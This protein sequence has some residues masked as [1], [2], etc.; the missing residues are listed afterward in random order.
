MCPN[1][2][3]EKRNKYFFFQYH[4]FL[5]K[6]INSILNI[7]NIVRVCVCVSVCE[8]QTHADSNDSQSFYQSMRIVWGTRVNKPE[9]QLTLNK[10]L[11]TEKEEVLSRWKDHFATLLNKTPTV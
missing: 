1:S 5:D 11:I 9:E 6:L 7:T 3:D 10:I 2:K 4:L 8:L